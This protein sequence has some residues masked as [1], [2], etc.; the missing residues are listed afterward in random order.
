MTETGMEQPVAGA[1][2]IQPDLGTIV[3]RAARM[4][5]S[6]PALITGGRV[7][8]YQASMRCATG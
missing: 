2:P 6:K 1:W 5:G 8:T 3:A 4:Y 7:L